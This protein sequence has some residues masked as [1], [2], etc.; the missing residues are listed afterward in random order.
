MATRLDPP[1][2]PDVSPLAH[3]AGHAMRAAWVEGCAK[4]RQRGTAPLAEAHELPWPQ[5]GQV[6]VDAVV[7]QAR[8]EQRDTEVAHLAAVLD[9]VTGL[10]R[11][12]RDATVASRPRRS[13]A[14]TAADEYLRAL[15]E[16]AG[17]TEPA[18]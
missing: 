3:Q 10:L 11:G 17:R 1:V 2:T 13:A 12:L 7:G 9:E 5:L 6:A 16:P 14:F 4:L 8:V 15:D 18:A